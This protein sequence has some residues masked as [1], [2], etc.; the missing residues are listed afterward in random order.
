[1]SLKAACRGLVQG[2][3]GIWAASPD[4]GRAHAES[5]QGQELQLRERVANQTHDN[6]IR[7]IAKHHSVPVMDHEVARF[8]DRT[9]RGAT[10]IDVGGCWG[11]HWRHI[12]QQRPDVTVVIVDFVRMNL[13][14]AQ[15]VL[16]PLV[17]PHVALVH[18]D[19]T[20][21]PFADGTFDAFWTVQTFQHI[22][23]F[24]LACR[25][26][27]RVLH[28][29]PF[30]CYFL[31]GAP[32]VKAIYRL[33]GRRLHIEGQV[34]GAYYLARAS[35]DHLRT[36]SDVFHGRVNSRYTECLFHP[37]LRATYAGSESNWLGR[38][39]ARLSEW[40][41]VGQLVARQCAFEAWKSE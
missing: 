18:G 26:A 22:P 35:A 2:E 6:Y 8:L 1:M 15:R 9:P 34:G 37:D 16:G 20:A 7:D 10:I 38:V 28:R 40:P 12:D 13:R 17:G 33:F 11:W 39:D 27:Y 29:G 30:A 4:E 3:D 24:S 23:N 19:A 25:E 41:R 32:L 21:L 14:H 5:E 31:H 36:V